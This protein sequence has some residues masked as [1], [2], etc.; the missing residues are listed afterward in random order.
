MEWVA[1]NFARLEYYDP[2]RMWWVNY[3]NPNTAMAEYVNGPMIRHD[4]REAIDAAIT[5][6][7]ENRDRTNLLNTAGRVSGS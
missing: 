7:K 3:S 4:Y 2:E 6:A 1:A 5:A